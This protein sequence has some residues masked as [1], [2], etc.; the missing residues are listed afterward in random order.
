MIG[1]KMAVIGMVVSIAAVMQGGLAQADGNIPFYGYSGYFGAPAV[2]YTRDGDV[3]QTTRPIDGK[4]GVGVRTYTTGGP[5]FG[6]KPAHTRSLP[7]RREA[8]RVRG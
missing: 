3:Q 6:Y 1:W 8:L 7:R 5:F 2:F 4:Q